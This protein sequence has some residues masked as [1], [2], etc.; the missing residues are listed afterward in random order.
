MAN[1]LSILDSVIIIFYLFLVILHGFL[2]ARKDTSEGF[3]IAERNLGAL[4]NTATILATKT[5][6]GLLVTFVALVYLYGVSAMWFFLGASTGYIIFIFF[7]VKLREI[8]SS[9]KFYTLS[10]YFFDQHGKTVGFISAAITLVYM[11]LALLLQLIGGAKILE[12]ISGISFTYSLLIIG[13]TILIYIALGGFRAVVKTDITQ[14]LL[15][16]L[17]AGL[18]G[19]VM[20]DGSLSTLH[21]AALIRAKTAPAKS[22]ISFFSF[23][24]ILPFASGEL[25]QRVYAAKNVATVRRSLIL[26]AIL[27][28]CIGLLLMIIGLEISAQV[29]VDDP[30]LVLIEGF[31]RLLPPGVLG[32]AVVLF[33]AAIMSSA[34]SYLFANISIL[35]Q[36]FYARFRPIEQAKLVRLFRYSLAIFLAICLIL[37]LYLRSMVAITFIALAVASIISLAAMAAWARKNIAPPTLIG[38]LVGGFTGVLVLVF[39]PPITE[40]LVLKIIA[41]TSTGFLIGS[42]LN[43]IYTKK[44]LSRDEGKRRY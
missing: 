24:I 18:L 4:A 14:L 2:T 43:W 6:A 39:L 17:V 27:Y 44:I 7:A 40:T 19:Y 15:I 22:I 31:I 11:L 5:G 20:W 28:P 16:V 9:K 33:L 29:R 3:L 42:V 38:G 35:L 25:W 34:D 26:S 13:I 37:S 21:S 30:D 8:S 41:F 36:D 1:V 23:G 32:L 12:Q 10:D